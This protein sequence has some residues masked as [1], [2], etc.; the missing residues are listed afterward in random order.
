MLLD[1]RDGIRNSTWLK[2]ILV[3]IICVPFVFFGV[4]SYFGNHGPDYA[5]KVNG[6]K[7][8][9]NDFQRAAQQ[10]QIQLQQS[11]GGQ[12][13]QGMDIGSLVNNQ[14]M[15]TVVRQEV[16]RQSTAGNGFAVGDEDLARQILAI[17]TFTVDGVFDKERYSN[18]LQS[19]GMS[20]T[21]FE[22]QYRGDLLMQQFRNS[23]VSTGFALGDE[24]QQIEA[25]RSQKR[26][27][28]FIKLETQ[29]K[30]DSLEV[31]DE[32]VQAHYDENIG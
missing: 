20:A 27:A 5:A 26:Q 3:G 4:S 21:D 23:V 12:L 9:V 6:Q 22:E 15:D 13:P 25:L 31:S 1:L 7:V 8:S 10:S 17:E 2:Y 32:E 28:S 11:F 29:A 14:A 24:N 19:S 16:L 18:F 30:A